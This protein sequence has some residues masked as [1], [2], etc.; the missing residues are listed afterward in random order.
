V[1]AR[2]AQKT[3]KRPKAAGLN[4]NLARE[5]MELHTLGVSNGGGVYGPWGG[6]TQADV[7]AFAAVLTGW[8]SPQPARGNEATIFDTNWHQPGPKT[9]LGKDYAEGQESLRLV[10][11]DLVAQPATSRFIATK[12]ARHFVA[13]DPPPAL[14]NRLAEAFRSSKGDLPTVYRALIDA[15]EA[16]NPA[17]A[18]LKTPEEFAISSAR[19][20]GLGDAVLQRGRDAGIKEMGQSP[21]S[22]K[23]PAG[24][25]DRAED[26]LGPD[27]LWKRVEW[28]MRITERLGVQADARMLA[29]DSFGPLLSETTATQVDRAVDGPQALALLM[30][31]PEFQRR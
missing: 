30:M 7:T 2:R 17:P 21:Q 14:V 5:V 29:R 3:G 16:W 1:L 9:V 24:W 19:V 23:S 20:L 31:A 26:W 28:S 22:A 27:A 15:P 6:Y 8:R 18:K 13:D 4:E 12:L 25:P 10:L 11:H